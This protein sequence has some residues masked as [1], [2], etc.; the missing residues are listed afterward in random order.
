MA[1]KTK[2]E[3]AKSKPAKHQPTTVAVAP[4]R[5]IWMTPKEW[6]KVPPNPFQKQNRAKRTNV[7]HLRHFEEEHA[8]VRMG[9]YPDGRLCKIDAHTRS[10]IWENRPWLVD[11]IPARLRVECYP[12]K[13]DA[14][15]AARFQ[16]VDNRKS[17]KN[18][19]DDV[20][21]SFRL[22]GISTE[23]TFFRNA[24]N[25]KSALTYAYAVVMANLLSELSPQ[26]R[27]AKLK[28][29]TIDDQV[30]HFAAALNALD[31]LNVN[32]SKLPAPF[33]TA[34]LVAYERHGTNIISFFQRVNAGT[35]GIKHGKKMC[36]IAA[37][38]RERDRHVGGGQDAHI[39]LTVQ[40]LGALEK[41]MEGDFKKALYQPKVDIERLMTVDIDQYLVREKVR[42]TGRT[43]KN[44]EMTR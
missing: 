31:A 7:A 6:A 12:V 5:I 38:E 3:P 42:R 25:I 29:S 21:G 24:S 13:D 15:A 33:V 2:T 44:R 16:R 27:A 22:A 26:E 37:L 34:F 41:Y 14:E 1:R 8:T 32:R 30:R 19:A 17:A 4:I 18:A 20:H 23:S 35:Y 9:I 28:Q 36:P 11:F 40:V 39:S 10:D 43:C